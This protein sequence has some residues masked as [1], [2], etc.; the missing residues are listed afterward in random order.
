MAGKNKA[1]RP[2]FEGWY[3]KCQTKD[4][5]TV[6]LIPAIHKDGN[7]QGSASL[8]VISESGTWWLEYPEAEFHVTKQPLQILLGSNTFSEEGISLQVERSG[9]SLHGELWNGPLTPL[10]SDIMGPFRFISELECTH[11]VVSMGHR[12]NGTLTLNGETL[13]F[14]GGLGYIETDRGRSFPDKYLWTQCSWVNPEV[15]GLMLAVATIP[16][17]KY[18]RFTG[19][20]CSIHYNK[21][22]YRLAAYKGA[23]I[24][25][26]SEHGAEVIQ[27]KYRLVVEV[28]EKQ[29]QPLRA[30]V[31]GAMGRIIHES[32]CSKVRYRFWEKGHLIFDHTD[33]G[34]SFEYAEKT[35]A[36]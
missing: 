6:A 28:L 29:G 20:I 18:V 30:P 15:T 35:T 11:G 17:L 33:D 3:F 32:L 22:E 12:L 2:Y 5:K 25:A 13:N 7:S 27:G 19:T 8:Q 34:A 24:K 10:Q 1:G 4:G 23:R 36:R 31:E 16:I 21:R 26:W 9:L 14:S